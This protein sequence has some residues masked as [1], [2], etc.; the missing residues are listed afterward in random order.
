MMEQ[1]EA[2]PSRHAARKYLRPRTGRFDNLIHQC[3]NPREFGSNPPSFRGWPLETRERA[4][5][6]LASEEVAGAIGIT[7]YVG[8]LEMLDAQQTCT[9]VERGCRARKEI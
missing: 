5:P 1:A 2:V 3:T 7:C 9:T 6:Q 4:N 8:H